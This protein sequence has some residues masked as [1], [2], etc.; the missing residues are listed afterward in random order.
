MSEAE[1][2][3]RC[4]AAGLDEHQE[5]LVLFLKEFGLFDEVGHDDKGA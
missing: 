5:R 3:Q 4:R 1:L 2:R